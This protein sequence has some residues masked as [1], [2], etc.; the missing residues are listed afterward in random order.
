MSSSNCCFLTCIQVSQE[1][2][3]VVW[4]SHLLQNSPLSESSTV[5]CGPYHQR[6]W[7]NQKAEI[8]V[9]L[10]LSCFF[11]DPAVVGNLISGS[12][13]FSKASWTSESSWFM[14]CWS[15]AWRILSITLLA[16]EMSQLC[17]SLSILQIAFLWAWNE[18][19]H[20]PVLWPLLS[21]P[22]CCHIECSTCTASYFRIWNSS[23]GIPSFVYMLLK[24]PNSYIVIWT[25]WLHF[26]CITCLSLNMVSLLICSEWF[27]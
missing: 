18:N 27:I 5:Y 14:Y 15:L 19:W 11:N 22:V 6:L 25:F 1:A 24:L 7:H 26:H 20:F 16:C 23:T 8:D 3:Q 13:A 4:Y 12:T 2:G 17:S 21:F 9:F 10:E